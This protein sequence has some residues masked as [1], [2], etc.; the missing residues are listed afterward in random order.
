[1]P[2]A[3]EILGFG[4]GLDVGPAAVETALPTGVTDLFGEALTGSLGL[5][6]GGL[7]LLAR[8]FR[9]AGN[10]LGA[11]LGVEGTSFGQA[12]S[13]LATPFL[14]QSLEE[15]LGLEP[16]RPLDPEIFLEALGVPE[17]P[18]LF[19]GLSSRDI[20]GIGVGLLL[21]PLTLFSGSIGRAVGRG[22]AAVD[23]RITNVLEGLAGAPTTATRAT[24]AGLQVGRGLQRAQLGLPLATG[25]LAAGGAALG[26]EDL[27]QVLG[28]GA[29]GAAA[30]ALP[31]A[32]PTLARGAIGAR[33]ALSKRFA[34]RTLGSI[35]EL[36]DLSASGRRA[37]RATMEL[38]RSRAK[39]LTAAMA[40]VTGRNVEKFRTLNNQLVD[41][42]ESRF[43]AQRLVE[44][45]DPAAF[46]RLIQA[47]QAGLVA[48]GLGTAEEVAEAFPGRAAVRAGEQTLDELVGDTLRQLDD[49]VLAIPQ[50]VRV[51]AS[52]L[53]AGDNLADI[54]K[55]APGILFQQRLLQTKNITQSER[56]QQ[57]MERI[58]VGGKPLARILP[59]ARA[60]EDPVD[61]Y[62]ELIRQVREHAPDAILQGSPD[63]K[64]L[65]RK[66]AAAE[67]GS[68]ALRRRGLSGAL[69]ELAKDFPQLETDVANLFVRETRNQAALHSGFDVAEQVTQNKAWVAD[70]I[71]DVPAS[72]LGLWEEAPHLPSKGL[73]DLFT[74][75]DGTRKLVRKEVARELFGKQGIMANLSDRGISKLGKAWDAVTNTWRGWTLSIFPAWMARNV[76]GNVWMNHLGNVRSPL[77]YKAG[78]KIHKAMANL[79]DP[80]KTAGNITVRGQTYPL[81]QMALDAFADGAAVSG[82]IST[83][84]GEQMVRIME[85]PGAAA[86]MLAI[87]PGQSTIARKGFA[88]NQTMEDWQRVTHYVAKRGEF[89]KVL[90]A[91]GEKGALNRLGFAVREGEDAI[92]ASRRY[93]KESVQTHLY[94]FD[95]LT[96]ADEQIR[97][98]IPFWR[99]FRQNMPAQ[100]KAVFTKPGQVAV[101]GKVKLQLDKNN[102][103]EVPEKFL[104]TWLQGQ[105]NTAVGRKDGK[106]SMFSMFG[107]LPLADI[108]EIDGPTKLMQFLVNAGHPVIRQVLEQGF[109]FSTFFEKEIERFDGER[110]H[111]LGYP[112]NRRMVQLLRNARI[113]NEFQN[114]IMPFVQNVSGEARTMTG[115]NQLTAGQALLRTA[116]IK[117]RPIDLEKRQVQV[118][119]ELKR[120]RD[121]LK[122]LLRQ[123]R[124]RGVRAANIDLL[125][126]RLQ[127]TK[128]Q[129]LLM[130]GWT[131]PGSHPALLSLADPSLN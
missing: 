15:L 59:H 102:R 85:T 67:A 81:R 76:I 43:G 12:A 108:Q 107:W 27:E 89:D 121:K 88:I 92:A 48:K 127:A 16:S 50:N 44:L 114:T 93:A 70:S 49:Q 21:D 84:V 33:E 118:V 55:F 8:P 57:L 58:S 87:D 122:G 17:G 61:V 80:A 77:L 6:E 30:G 20:G 13:A 62:R 25:G 10:V 56:V 109:N 24:A 99:W 53:M 40:E 51:A 60:I 41:V 125:E 73:R 39:E 90:K 11:T 46:G 128:D 42:L 98:V 103:A 126:Q 111:F 52:K 120:E 74:N 38:T 5:L 79:R 64:T 63:I 14:P 26:G 45:T 37:E 113:I 104:P 115:M 3:A 68:Q 94:G 19:L 75:A 117:V 78:K 129:L 71:V 95:D 22:G 9:F 106:L 36:L 130:T 83:E 4:E 116:G 34:G 112:L 7:D 124:K 28:A 82:H 1:M 91:S 2:T 29:L 47:E 66:L 72:Q 31:L 131:M 100:A 110:E 35:D 32:L 69:T 123:E 105:L 119:R 54:D 23:R 18:E 97:R 101:V 65:A 96:D 86:K